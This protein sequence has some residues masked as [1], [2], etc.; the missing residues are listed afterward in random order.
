MKRITSGEASVGTSL[1]AKVGASL[2]TYAG[3]SVVIVILVLVK[4][5]I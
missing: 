2:I 4:T 5:L 3:A 1:R